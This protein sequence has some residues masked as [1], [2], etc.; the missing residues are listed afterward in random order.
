MP[1]YKVSN[2]KTGAAFI[3]QASSVETALA[4]THWDP[5]SCLVSEYSWPGGAVKEEPKQKKHK[6]KRQ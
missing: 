4:Q 2:R 6:G 1:T 5:E 3:C